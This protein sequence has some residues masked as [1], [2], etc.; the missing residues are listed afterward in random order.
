[1]PDY[2]L[3]P[4]EIYLNLNIKKHNSGTNYYH[5]DKFLEGYEYESAYHMLP[6]MVKSPLNPTKTKEGWKE[7][8]DKLREYGQG[9]G[10]PI[11]KRFLDG[12]KRDSVCYS[13]LK[14]EEYNFG[15]ETDYSRVI[16]QSKFQELALDPVILN[17]PSLISMVCLPRLEYIGGDGT[18][19]YIPKFRKENPDFIEVKSDFFHWLEIIPPI[20]HSDRIKKCRYSDEIVLAAP[21][22][23]KQVLPSGSIL[24]QMTEKTDFTKFDQVYWDKL[25]ELYQYFIDKPMLESE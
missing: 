5:F 18:R 15:L 14:N 9:E 12:S 4:N 17:D 2:K 11:F 16:D 24:L 21:Y 7:V 22:F 13:Y 23:K 6:K 20:I 3:Q 1:M 8:F 19:N 25:M 10:Y